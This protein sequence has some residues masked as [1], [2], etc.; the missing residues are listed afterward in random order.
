M[1]YKQLIAIVRNKSLFSTPTK[2]STLQTEGCMYA[3]AQVWRTCL[4]ATCEAI[5]FG[6]SKSAIPATLYWKPRYSLAAKT[7]A[8]AKGRFCTLNHAQ[9]G[10]IDSS[11]YGTG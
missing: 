8:K 3:I 5:I 11:D 4:L 1:E 6:G 9:I 10:N 7:S 2:R